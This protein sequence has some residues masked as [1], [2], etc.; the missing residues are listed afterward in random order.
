MKR[1]ALART[2]LVLLLL[3]PTAH[4]ADLAPGL[5]YVRAPA[6]TAKNGDTVQLPAS[7][8]SLI[9]DLRRADDDT[10]LSAMVASLTAANRVP[11]RVILVLIAPETP[12]SLR[13][14]F[15]TNRPSC[16]TIGRADDSLKTDIAVTTTA[17]ADEKAVAALASG[18]EPEKLIAENGDKPRF[19]ESLLVREHAVGSEPSTSLDPEAK[20]ADTA[21]KPGDTVA[22]PA[23]ADAVLQRAVQVYRGLVALKKIP[24]R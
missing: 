19:D 17:E 6:K 11:R 24:A 15:E 16:I 14:I 3:C 22:P 7:G 23:I 4:A 20:P 2:L 8:G 12:A 10:D 18:T 9:L 13:R 5:A 21:S 1:L